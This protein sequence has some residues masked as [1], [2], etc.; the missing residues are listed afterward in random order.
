M[1]Y[2]DFN[3]DGKNIYYNIGV[4]NKEDK[5]KEFR[6]FDKRA[7]N[8]VSSSF[9]YKLG[10]MRFSVDTSEIPI[11]YF[12]SIEFSAFTLNNE[13]STPNNNY[14][15]ITVD[16][17]TGTINQEF[18]KHESFTNISNDLRIFT[19]DQF[20][21][22]LNKA[23]AIACFATSVNSLQVPYFIYDKDL[24]IIN[25]VFTTAWGNLM[26]Q[27]KFYMNEKL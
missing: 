3:R 20:L 13:Y 17:D 6:Y 10:V 15:S 2:S 11:M 23:I 12:P 5:P 8:L 27:H 26:N 24:G 25:I 16:D 4:V 14:Y 19:I 1:R 18:I 9:K 22:M 7:T 21:Q